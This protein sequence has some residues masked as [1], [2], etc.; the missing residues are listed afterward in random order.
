MVSHYQALK[1]RFI[2]TLMR[3]VHKSLVAGI[4]KVPSSQKP[5]NGSI[6]TFRPFNLKGMTMAKTLE[7]KM[8]SLTSERRK[9]I[10][11]MAAKL[12]AEESM[13]QIMREK[14]EKI[15]RL[16]NQL[17]SMDKGSAVLLE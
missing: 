4:L 8:I 16:Q 15:L 9:K 6:N 7:E 10:E 11:D 5:T 1:A 12:I 2:L 13:R 14:Q 3:H 17:K